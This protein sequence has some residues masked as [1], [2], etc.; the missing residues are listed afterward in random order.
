MLDVLLRFVDRCEQRDFVGHV[1]KVDVIRKALDR[2]KHLFLHAH[3]S[4]CSPTRRAGKTVGV[5]AG[6]EPALDAVLATAWAR[7][8][9]G[10]QR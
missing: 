5:S 6:V 10:V 4:E 3:D 1:A 8:A 2:L 9:R 7:K